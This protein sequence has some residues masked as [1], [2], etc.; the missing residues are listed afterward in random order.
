MFHALRN[1]LPRPNSKAIVIVVE[2]NEQQSVSVS[3]GRMRDAATQAIDLITVDSLGLNQTFNN[4]T[5]ATATI[6]GAIVGMQ[7]Q[8]YN[9]LRAGMNSL[10]ASRS[11]GGTGGPRGCYGDMLNTITS[12]PALLGLHP[13]DAFIN[14]YGEAWYAN[15]LREMATPYY[16]RV[17][18]LTDTTATF[19]NF[20]DTVERLHDEGYAIDLL[21]DQH[22]CG[23]PTTMNN[24]SCGDVNPFLLFSDGPATR[25]GGFS[26]VGSGPRPTLRSINS[27]DA[28]SAS[29]LGYVRLDNV[30]MVSCWGS[31]FNQM[32]LD[33]GARASNGPEQLNYFILTSPLTFLDELTRNGASLEQASERAYQEERRTLFDIQPLHYRLD[34]TALPGCAG[35]LFDIDLAAVYR[36]R[37]A[38][39]LA[40][41]Y[42]ADHHLPVEPERSSR[43]V[44]VRTTSV[45]VTDVNVYV[46]D[47]A[48]G[49][50]FVIVTPGSITHTGSVTLE[51]TAQGPA[52]AAH[53]SPGNPPQMYNLSTTAGFS[54]P[55]QVCFT[56]DETRFTDESTLRLLHFEHGQWLDRTVSLDTVANMI[57]GSVTSFS[58]FAVIEWVNGAPVVNP[59]TAVTDE[60]RAIDIALS[61]SDADGDALTFALATPPAH[62]HVV[63]TGSIARYTPARDYNGSDAFGFVASDGVAT[64]R[65]AMVSVTITPVNDA[66]VAVTRNVTRSAGA[67]CQA[68]VTP[69]DVDGGSTDPDGDPIVLA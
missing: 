4:F 64:S 57:C 60:D 62:G 69:Q 42:G 46:T 37:L 25:D 65:P 14:R 61:A 1:I 63:I 49:S 6:L 47:P 17:E 28:G 24:R 67:S 20:K 43:R 5:E 39:A 19:A 2:N 33:M 66:P 53:Q 13:W 22:G 36:N 26:F 29:E 68:G 38:V 35:C 50:P 31:N 44:H 8:L 15:C 56:Y 51:T 52:L 45:A 58:P 30:Y 7:R 27:F 18:V 3:W 9:T 48:T 23:K 34:L 55:T 11:S 40:A 59:S 12:D 41:E 54:G 16:D 10:Q 32:W 21:L